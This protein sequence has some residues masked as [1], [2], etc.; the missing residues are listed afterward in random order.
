MA[1]GPF[2]YLGFTDM[3]WG[4]FGAAVSPFYAIPCQTGVAADPRVMRWDA[5]S[6]GLQADLLGILEHMGVWAE[7]SALD[8]VI[9]VGVVR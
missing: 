5:V 6:T 2:L 3:I 1:P 4:K 8:L 9:G 7:R